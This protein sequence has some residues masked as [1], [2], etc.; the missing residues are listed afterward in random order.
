MISPESTRH[1]F[2]CNI[3][4]MRCKLVDM[5]RLSA[6]MASALP[7]HPIRFIDLLKQYQDH[8]NEFDDLCEQNMTLLSSLS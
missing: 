6:G 8:R 2:R 4:L 7:F 1:L 3:T 5:K